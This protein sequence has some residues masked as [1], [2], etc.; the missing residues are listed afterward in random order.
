MV[1]SSNHSSIAKAF[2]TVAAI[3]II[4][5]GIKTA[6]NI[7]VPFLLSVFIAIICNPLINKATEYKIPKAV[8]V[9]SVIVVFVT[10]AVFL[11]GLVGSSLNELSQQIPQYRV[12]LKEQFIHR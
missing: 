2:V 4:F 12:Q 9:I 10:L 8:S 11:T 3:F 6:A 1:S 7:L 5:A